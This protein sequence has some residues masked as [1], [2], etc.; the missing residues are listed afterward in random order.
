M[1]QHYNEQKE[2]KDMKI[3]DFEKK[4]TLL[5]SLSRIEIANTGEMTGTIHHTK[6]TLALSMTV[7]WTDTQISVS[8]LEFQC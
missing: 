6:I 2:K 7:L 5:D 1:N 8:V 3:I 4:E